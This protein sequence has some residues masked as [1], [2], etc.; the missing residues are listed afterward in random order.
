VATTVARQQVRGG[1]AATTSCCCAFVLHREESIVLAYQGWRCTELQRHPLTSFVVLPGLRSVFR[2]SS[3]HRCCSEGTHWLAYH[4]T[5]IY[6]A[7]F[8][9]RG[10]HCSTNFWRWRSPT[11][12]WSSTNRVRVLTK[13]HTIHG[14]HMCDYCRCACK[15]AWSNYSSNAVV[16]CRF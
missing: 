15:K 12:A 7:P 3:P 5:F 6:Y 13:A 11:V 1:D 2:Q 9:C 10:T 8:G 16:W 14:L 4:E